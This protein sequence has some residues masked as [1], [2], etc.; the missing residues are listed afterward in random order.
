ML[1]ALGLCIAL[2]PWAGSGLAAA[3]TR[4]PPAPSGEESVNRFACG[5]K[6]EAQVLSSWDH[7]IRQHLEQH[8]LQERL[9][10][11]HDVYA[12]YDFQTYAHN[13][14]AM[15]RRCDRTERLLE[16]ARLIGKAYGALAPGTFFSPGRRWV[17]G[18]G[19]TCN[20]T[21]GLLGKEVVLD[22]VQFLGIASSVANA[23]A[24]SGKPVGPEGKRFIEETAAVVT[25]HLLRWGNALAVYKLYGMAKARPQDVIDGSSALF[26]TDQPLWMITVYAELSA[27]L[28]SQD[29]HATAVPKRAVARMRAHLTALLKFFSARISLLRMPDSRI[30][31]VE[32]ADID[33]G[34]WMRYADNRYAGYEKEEKPVTC[35][36]EGNGAP[37]A[38][39][40]FHVPPDD[41]LRRR[42]AGWDISHARRLVH[43]LDALERNRDAMQRVFSLPDEV[44][45]PAILPLAFANNLIAVVWNGDMAKPLFSNYWSGANGWFR[46]AYDNGTG[47]CNEGYPPYGMSDSFMTGGYVAWTR[48]R[49][50]IGLLGKRLYTL[51]DGADGGKS[52]WIAKYYSGFGGSADATSRALTQFMF[53]PTLVGVGIE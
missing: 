52:A 38:K 15:A 42:D 17:C 9:L 41:A 22:S 29:R 4:A 40:E 20:D 35:P 5:G 48:Y 31:N 6:L 16:V 36:S 39:P 21:N 44:L 46:V 50:E 18:G 43:A 53:L 8:L 12:L 34:Y 33:R 32:I 47:S 37:G 19:D 51:S 24:S 30:G 28:A 7:G 3:Q 13:F 27:I 14:V 23:M 1:R 11:K 10:E 2:I 49:P 25:E 26:F 45:P